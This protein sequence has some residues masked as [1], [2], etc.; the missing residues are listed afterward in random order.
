MNWIPPARYRVFCEVDLT[1]WPF[2]EHTCSL[3]LGSWTYDGNA[4]SMQ[5]SRN[6]NVSGTGR[7]P[8]GGRG[9]DRTGNLNS[10]SPLQTPNMVNL[11]EGCKWEIV[12]VTQRR[13]VE[14]YSCNSD[15][16]YED[17]HYSITVRRRIPAYHGVVVIPAIGKRIV[18]RGGE[19]GVGSGSATAPDEN[20][21]TQLHGV[22][23]RRSKSRNSQQ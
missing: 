9:I 20:S 23:G 3:R 10:F 22:V 8:G 1:N 13:R 18:V 5:I 17:V 16:V 14:S 19:R 12:G 21:V 7:K 11:D 2:G 4:V 15:D 6:A